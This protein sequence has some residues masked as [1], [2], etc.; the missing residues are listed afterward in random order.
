M[1][2]VILT[3]GSSRITYIRKVIGE[4]FEQDK[5]LIDSN[6][7]NS[8]SRGLSSYAYHKGIKIT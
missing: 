2:K 7:H 4:T 3:G 5:I 1:D 8:V 6:L